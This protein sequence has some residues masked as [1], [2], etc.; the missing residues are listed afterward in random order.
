MKFIKVKTTNGKDIIINLLNVSSFFPNGENI[1]TIYFGNNKDY[2]NVGISIEA[3]HKE[4]N[5]MYS[6]CNIIGCSKQ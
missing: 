6:F 4:L 1:T 2:V 5:R 3:L